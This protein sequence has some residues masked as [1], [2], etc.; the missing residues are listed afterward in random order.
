[1]NSNLQ[2]ISDNNFG[3]AGKEFSY[4]GAW[5]ILPL[6]HVARCHRLSTLHGDFHSQNIMVTDVKSN[7]RVTAVIDWEFSATVATSTFSQYPFF[8]VDHLVGIS[9]RAHSRL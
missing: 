8:I 3:I 2:D 1:M 6:R 5:F 9:V 4:S 7:P